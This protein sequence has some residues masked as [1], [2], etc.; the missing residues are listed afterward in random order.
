VFLPKQPLP[1]PP[2][3]VATQQ[4][5]PNLPAFL[6]PPAAGVEMPMA[7]L[8]PPPKSLPVIL[9]KM[10]MPTLN[11]LD[12]PAF[13]RTPA[14][15]SITPKIDPALTPVIAKVV[16]TPGTNLP[17]AIV[18]VPAESYLGTPGQ[19]PAE[20]LWQPVLDQARQKQPAASEE[21]LPP[22]SEKDLQQPQERKLPAAVVQMPVLPAAVETLPTE[23]D[24]LPT[25]GD[26]APIKRGGSDLVP[27]TL[28]TQTAPAATVPAA[29]PAPHALQQ[30]SEPSARKTSL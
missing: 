23:E 26:M 13:L 22:L 16:Q 21:V 15:K 11:D 8:V 2:P 14:M 10:P 6:R 9:A 30:P 19:L 27:V 24:L 3:M 28:P 20:L 12:L 18:Q 7:F 17:A 4:P 29:A 1:W 5:P 25:A